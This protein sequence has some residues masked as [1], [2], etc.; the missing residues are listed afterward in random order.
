MAPNSVRFAPRVRRIYSNLAL[1]TRLDYA[2]KEIRELKFVI[3]SLYKRSK[4]LKTAFKGI[5]SKAGAALEADA[6]DAAAAVLR[7]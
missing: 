3:Q 1:K 7:V 2:M 6:E 5:Q 4:K